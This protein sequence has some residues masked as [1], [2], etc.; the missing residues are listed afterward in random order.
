[1]DIIAAIDIE[2]TRLDPHYHDIIELAVQPLTFCFA[3]DPSIPPFVARIKVRRPQNAS[4]KAWRSMDLTSTRERNIA[5]WF[6]GWG[7]GLLVM[8]S[9]KFRFS[10][11]TWTSTAPSF[12]RR[13]PNSG[14]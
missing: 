4:P 3:F 14:G 13:F 1:M 2:T 10:G 6:R 12:R 7:T 9:A 11:R 8:K 5:R